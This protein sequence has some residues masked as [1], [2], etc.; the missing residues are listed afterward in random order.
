M[1]IV[2]T[3]AIGEGQYGIIAPLV[4]SNRVGRLVTANMNE[5]FGLSVLDSRAQVGFFAHLAFPND[6]T[7]ITPQILRLRE[8]GARRVRVETA[9]LYSDI[10]P[11]NMQRET[12]SS[13][14]RNLI[15][16]IAR[17][18]M[19]RLPV[20]GFMWKNIGRANKTAL[21]CEE[22]LHRIGTDDLFEWLSE[23]EIQRYDQSA[24]AR[25]ISISE[26]EDFEALKLLP[27]TCGYEPQGPIV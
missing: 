6:I 23:E 25:S 24:R 20:E 17:L 9:N 8:Y 5:C 18:Y 26:A 10:I 21:D 7:K 3:R 12:Y 1:Q 15:V 19:N 14:I 4:D 11:K 16:L 22:G 13:Q 2:E 27:I